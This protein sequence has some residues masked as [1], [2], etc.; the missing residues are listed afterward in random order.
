P[1]E[2]AFERFRKMLYGDHPYG[3]VF[4]TEQMVKGFRQADVQKFYDDNFGARRTRVYVAG[5]FEPAP[6]K[7]ALTEGLAG[8]KA[9]PEPLVNPPRPT[10]ERTL[11]LVEKPEAVQSTIYMGLPTVDPS[12]PEYVGMQVMQTLL[13]GGGFLARI[14]QNIRENKGYT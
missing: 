12:Q 7:A 5:M 2:L 9:G 13:G 1:R 3:R 6:V 4:P 10:S 14:T 8:W 11:E